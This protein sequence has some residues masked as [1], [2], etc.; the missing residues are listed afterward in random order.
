M[1]PGIDGRGGMKLIYGIIVAG[2]KVKLGREGKVCVCITIYMCI[3]S[4]FFL[5]S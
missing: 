3:Y 1:Y 2:E 5:S 4:V